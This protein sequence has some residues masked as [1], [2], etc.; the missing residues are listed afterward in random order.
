MFPTPTDD[1]QGFNGPLT[2]L[3]DA[4]ACSEYS[5]MHWDTQ[6][7]NIHD[8]S[9]FLEDRCQSSPFMGSL[10]GETTINEVPN[11]APNSVCDL[12]YLQKRRVW[13]PLGD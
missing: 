8:T 7:G 11:A 2:P 9:H 3:S 1:F 5:S 10:A 6:T 12:C 13:L 4:S